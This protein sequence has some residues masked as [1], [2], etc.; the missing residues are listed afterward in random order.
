VLPPYFF[1]LAQADLV[2]FFVRA[3]EAAQLPLFL[4]NFPE[5]TGNR[6]DLETVAAVADRVPLAGVKQSG[7]EFAYHRS[8]AELG[9]EKEF[10]VFSGSDTRLPEAMALGAVG[11]V[12][13]LANAVPEP[14]VAIFEAVKSNQRELVSNPI[15]FMRAM[16]SLV[17][18]VAFPLNVA[19]AMEARGQRVGQ[20]K[21]VVSA[22]T[23][24]RYQKLVAQFRHLYETWKL[25]RKENGVLE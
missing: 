24:A 6:I 12:S 14:I 20:P 15:E 21:S 4:Y 18:E 17:D 25:S 11:C 19:A 2:E 10:V 7:G 22:A 9:R 3:G 1:P 23:Q 16:G 13:G 5:R 8:L